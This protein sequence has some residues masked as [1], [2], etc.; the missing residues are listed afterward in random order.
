LKNL[1]RMSVVSA[2]AMSL[3]ACGGGAKLK[4]GKENAAAAVFTASQG[5]SRSQGGLMD[6]LRQNADATV[7]VKVNCTRGGDVTLHWIAQSGGTGSLAKFD[8]RYSNCSH[9]GRT[10]MNGTMTTEMTTSVS[11]GQLV[12]ELKLT[13]RIDFSGEVSDYVVANVTERLDVS[14]LSANQGVSVS[15][16][17]NGTIQTSTETYTYNNETLSVVAGTIAA[18]VKG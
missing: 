12:A 11:S 4:P 10:T 7:D 9:D 13:G 5:A 15:L 8:L 18:D 2:V 17:F 3:F 16:I 6:I 1:I 14:K